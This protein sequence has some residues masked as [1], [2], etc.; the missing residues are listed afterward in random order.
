MLRSMFVFPNDIATLGADATVGSLSDI[1]CNGMM[2]STGYHRSRHLHPR[3]PG[4]L[5]AYQADDGVAFQPNPDRY[6]GTVSPPIDLALSGAG[7]L[8]RAREAAQKRGQRFEAWL[9]GLHN[10]ALGI[11]H[12]ELTSQN[13][14]G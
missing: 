11:G 2:L 4:S 14:F 6:H 7:V 1:G 8:H 9:M 12:P 3:W 13:A 5:T 10:S